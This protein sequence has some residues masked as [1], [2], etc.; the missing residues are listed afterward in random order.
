MTPIVGSPLHESNQAFWSLIDTD[1]H[2]V[3]PVEIQMRTLKEWR[4]GVKLKI[5][6]TASSES[7]SPPC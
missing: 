5:D 7:P 2:S 1:Q 6:Q 4:A 3:H